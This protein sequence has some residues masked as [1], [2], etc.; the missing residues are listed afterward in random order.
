MSKFKA[1]CYDEIACPSRAH[2]AYNSV[3]FVRAAAVCAK[4]KRKKRFGTPLDFMRNFMK[5]FF[6]CTQTHFPELLAMT[7][8]GTRNQEAPSPVAGRYSRPH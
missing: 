6:H 1:K 5:L 7:E 3:Y 4:R 8:G 2:A